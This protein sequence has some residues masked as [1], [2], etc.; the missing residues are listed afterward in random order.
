MKRALS[1]LIIYFSVVFVGTLLL[2]LFFMVCADLTVLVAGQKI[3]VFNLDFFIKGI[4]I[5]FPLMAAFAPMFLIFFMV[6][7]PSEYISSLITYVVL[8]A[9]TW[10]LLIPGGLKIYENIEMY[11]N[12]ISES[13]TTGIFREEESGIFYYSRILENGNADGLYIDSPG[14]YGLEGSVIPFYDIPVSKDSAY[15]YSDSIIK[16]AITPPAMVSYPLSVYNAILT[17]AAHAISSGYLK[18]LCFSAFGLAL[19]SVFSVQFSSSWKLANSL[20]IIFAILVICFSNFVYY[21][22]MIP[23]LFFEFN[24]KLSSALHVEDALILLVNL[25][26]TVI[27]LFWGIGMGLYRTRKV[28]AGEEAK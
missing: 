15:P 12:K 20:C 7:H 6:R 5:A 17:A 10:L 13:T 27:L 2:G 3:I 24:G 14:F 8:G 26:F 23:R 25:I 1:L 28:K 16:K 11:D 18:W 19:L 21:M 9:I 22:G 4:L